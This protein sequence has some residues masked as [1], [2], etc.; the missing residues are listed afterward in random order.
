MRRDFD[1]HS[2]LLVPVLLLLGSLAAGLHGQRAA[3][4]KDPPPAA[5]GSDLGQH[6][7]SMLLP[8]QAGRP[9]EVVI[10]QSAGDAGTATEVVLA[11]EQD[12]EQAQQAAGPRGG[13][14]KAPVARPAASRAWSRL[15]PGSL[16]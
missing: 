1:R 13:V 5:R 4:L 12:R 11:R 9:L 3:L 2:V 14:L 6:L 8:E 15:L 16:R 7:W 10:G